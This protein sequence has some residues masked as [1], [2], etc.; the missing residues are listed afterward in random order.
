VKDSAKKY[1][2]IRLEME[3]ADSLRVG[4][5]NGDSYIN[6]ALYQNQIPQDAQLAFNLSYDPIRVAS[7]LLQEGLIW[8]LWVL[9]GIFLYI[10]PG[11]ALL[12]LLWP[13]WGK[14]H[15]GEKLGLSAGV[16]LAIYPIIFLWTHLIGLSL[17]PLYAWIPP[18]VSFS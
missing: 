3:G 2:Y 4:I 12:G 11:W 5:S 1:Y 13:G 14:L 18:I 10:I 17:G 6:G 15:W 16:S 7:G 9:I 8:I